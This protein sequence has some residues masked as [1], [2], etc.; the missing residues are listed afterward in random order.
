M[1]KKVDR[2]TCIPSLFAEIAASFSTNSYRSINAVKYPLDITSDPVNSVFE[3]LGQ[4]SVLILCECWSQFCG[5]GCTGRLCV[6][7]EVLVFERMK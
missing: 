1:V 3:V 2:V 6:G 5:S 7:D 4:F